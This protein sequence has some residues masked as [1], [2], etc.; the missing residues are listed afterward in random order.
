MIT[1]EILEVKANVYDRIMASKTSE[2]LANKAIICRYVEATNAGELYAFDEFV[3]PDY[4]EH[5]PV[6][7]QGPG[8]EELKK[9]YVM[10]NTPF[11]DL[12][13]IFEDVIAEGDM[14][15]GR[16]VISGTHA[17]EFFGIPGTGKK[18]QWT[19]TRLFRLR[20][21]QV[22]EGWINLD[23]LGL[24]QQM[25]VAPAPPQPP[26]PLQIPPK[27]TGAASTRA[28]NRALMERFIEEV[29][30]RGNLEVADEIFHPQA[31]SPSAP[32]LPPGAE[33]VKAIATMFRNA[34]PDFWMEIEYMVAEDDRVAARFRQGGTHKGE[35]MGIAP[36]GKQVSWTETG[37]LRVADGKVVE[38]WYDVDMI[39]LMQQLGVIPSPGQ[40]SV[41]SVKAAVTSE[42]VLEAYGALASGDIARI[43]QY[44]DENMVWQVPGHNELS[45]WYHNL[46]EFLA[47]M[48]EVGKLS[49]NS[50]QME[51]IAGQVLV[52][53]EYSCDLTRNRGHRNGHSDK[54]MDIEVAHVLRWKEGKV[55]AGKG[56]IFGD[57]TTEYDQFWSRSPVV[58]PSL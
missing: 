45:G 46:N 31:F 58:T 49:D 25:G 43:K 34:F 50:F 7:G 42:H 1:E 16:G 33:G 51:P 4:V 52:T 35:L 36:T 21:G 9:A 17:G 32:N 53:G 10:F 57:G 29:W 38:S 40:E 28:A 44:W 23:M 5:D 27:I 47:F 12:E 30:N 39:G 20:N 54:T 26:A 15:I 55:I 37:I 11:P 2:E 6:Q 8:R 13:Y 41:E 22:T 56:A 14:V 18:L 3:D 24:M 19:G 48:S